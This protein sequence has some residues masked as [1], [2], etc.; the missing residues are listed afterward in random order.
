MYA[1]KYLKYK[2]KYNTLK[3]ILKGGVAGDIE[4]NEQPPESIEVTNYLE[5]GKYYLSTLITHIQ[6]LKYK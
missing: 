3:K 4:V 6:Y 1:D 2:S 5:I